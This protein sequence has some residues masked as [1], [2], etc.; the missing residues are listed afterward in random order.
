[1]TYQM[2]PKKAIGKI[3]WITLSVCAISLL[4]L[5]ITG[6]IPGVRI[7]LLIS[8]VIGGLYLSILV[9]FLN[10]YLRSKKV[11]FDFFPMEGSMVFRKGEQV[12]KFLYS[13]ILFIEHG[14]A[15]G[16]YSKT[17][18]ITKIPWDDFFYTKFHF[19]NGKV[20]TL[21]GFV[22]DGKP[23]DIRGVEVRRKFVFYPLV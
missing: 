14:L 22:F 10:H 15:P 11:A 21:S 18:A 20:I 9:I 13:D 19:R 17:S 2:N 6:K 7:A 8:M 5:L 3:V 16:I 4:M 23:V 1:M 12:E